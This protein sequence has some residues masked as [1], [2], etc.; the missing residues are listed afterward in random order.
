[1]YKYKLGDKFTIINNNITYYGT[2]IKIAELNE[3]G[4]D[5]YFDEKNYVVKF[6]INNLPIATYNFADINGKFKYIMTESDI[7]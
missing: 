3:Y 1:M 4:A 7:K 2:I 5:F 6:N